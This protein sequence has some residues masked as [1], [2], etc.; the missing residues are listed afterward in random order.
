MTVCISE[1]KVYIESLVPKR[2]DY[3]PVKVFRRDDDEKF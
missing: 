2:G 3:F 1:K